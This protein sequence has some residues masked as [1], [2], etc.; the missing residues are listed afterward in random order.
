MSGNDAHRRSRPSLATG[1]WLVF[2]LT[3]AVLA[4]A[5]K[6]DAPSPVTLAEV[7]HETLRQEVRLSGTSIPWR[8][9]RLSPRVEGLATRVLVDVGA[10]VKP[11]DPI[12]ELD[13]RLADIEIDVAQA[14][15]AGADARRRDAM[16]KRDELMRLQ[17]NRHTSETAIESAIAD[18]AIATADLTR[19][20]AEL[21]RARE[22]RERHAVAAPFAGMVVSK[23]VEV[24]QW[25]QRDDTLIEL[26]EMDTLRV[27]ASLPQ[28][29]YPSVAVGA[30]AR[31]EFDALP[32][33]EFNGRIFARVALGNEASRSFPLLIDIDNRDH[34]LAPGMSAR[35]GIELDNGTTAAMTVPRDAVVA[36]SSGERVVWRVRQDR[37]ELKVYPVSVEPGRAHGDRLEVISTE[38][39]AGDRIVML[40]NERLRPGQAVRDRTAGPT[41]V[42]NE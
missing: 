20:Q 8:H 21:A 32:E 17:K 15:V 6:K 31:V 24:G 12:V 40:G 1:L 27:Q 9:V 35:V 41:T 26:V 38:L 30:R 29:Y 28:R 14:R 10:W 7:L 2:G 5:D 42:A 3:S 39:Q 16:R 23:D 36:K 34:Q 37:D 18:L 33:R 22:L 4:Q 25:V 19:E 13:A 11:G